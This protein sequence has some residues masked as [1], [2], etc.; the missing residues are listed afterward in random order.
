V[1]NQTVVNFTLLLSTMAINEH[2]DF[3][4]T[5]ATQISIARRI[6]RLRKA[7]GWTLADVQVRSHGVIKAVVLGS[8][9]RGD[10]SMS[11][12]RAIE[13]ADL[14]GIPL[15]ELL[16]EPMPSSVEDGPLGVRVDALVVDLRKVA[17]TNY[18]KNDSSEPLS[19]FLACIIGKRQ[20]WNGEVLSLRASDLEIL[21]LMMF[22]SQESVMSWLNKYRLLIPTQ[23]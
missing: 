13:I 19:L 23:R 22:K 16:T 4:F 6:R 17:L 3:I 5:Q 7:R 10:R 9:E 20:D 14:F 12:E 2:P 8:Y 11:I 21:S 1:D 18:E 15:A